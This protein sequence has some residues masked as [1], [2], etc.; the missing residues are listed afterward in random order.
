[1]DAKTQ[2]AI[3][4]ALSIAVTS[5][6]QYVTLSAPAQNVREANR[7]ANYECRNQL[8]LTL[9]MLHQEMSE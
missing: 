1:M 2:A 7:E 3:V 4:S 5:V 6:A 9:E 8:K